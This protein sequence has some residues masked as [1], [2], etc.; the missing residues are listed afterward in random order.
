MCVRVAVWPSEATSCTACR[1]CSSS[2]SVAV[3]VLDG[4]LLPLGGLASRGCGLDA[5]WR[6][7]GGRDSRCAD[8]A[9]LQDGVYCLVVLR[10]RHLHIGD[11]RS[12]ERGVLSAGHVGMWGNAQT[13]CVVNVVIIGLPETPRPNMFGQGA[14]AGAEVRPTSA[15]RAPR[16]KILGHIGLVLG[17]ALPARD[18][19]QR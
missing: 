1:A 8:V 4:A 19:R 12:G 9:L 15:N 2:S 16:E 11:A 10:L 7:I 18:D 6:W 3:R 5:Q 13:D 17:I 14:A